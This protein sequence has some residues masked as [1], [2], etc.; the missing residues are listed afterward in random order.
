MCEKDHRLP[1]QE[2]K[3]FIKC[4]EVGLTLGICPQEKS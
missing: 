2:S 4:K 3:F 1:H